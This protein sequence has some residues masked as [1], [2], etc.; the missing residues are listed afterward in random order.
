MN[1]WVCGITWANGNFTP[2]QVQYPDKLA[3]YLEAVCC[4]SRNSREIQII[5]KC[6]GLA[7]AYLAALFNTIQ[8]SKRQG[9][10]N[11][12]TGITAHPAPPTG[13]AAAAALEST[14][15]P[16]AGMVAA[17]TPAAG[18]MAGP[19]NQPMPVLVTPIQKNK[20]TKISVHP[21]KDD[22]EPGPSQEQEKEAE[23]EIIT[24]SSMYL[25]YLQDTQ[26][27]FHHHQGEHIVTW[28]LSCWDNG[29]SSLEI[30]G[31]E[32]KQMRSLS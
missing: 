15:D 27:D 17:P 29:A 5:S 9:E 31:R 2:E 12:M 8:C 11:K 10:K 6:C 24:R 32:A 1:G 23:P 30:E 16:A 21:V 20:Y 4:Q 7:H 13:T 28:L 19:E 3:E 14:P 26:K 18:T 25:S 22:N